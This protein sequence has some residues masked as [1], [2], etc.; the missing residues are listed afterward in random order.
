MI[1]EMTN[2]ETAEYI[3]LHANEKRDRFSWI[4]DACGYTQ[5]MRFVKHRSKNWGGGTHEE[6]VRFLLDYADG[7][8]EEP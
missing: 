8:E 4:T 7:L 3:H 6:W 1:N 2:A 5:H